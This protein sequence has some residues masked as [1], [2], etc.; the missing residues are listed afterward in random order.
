MREEPFSNSPRNQECVSPWSRFRRLFL[1]LV[2]DDDG[3]EATCHRASSS[4]GAKTATE[5]LPSTTPPWPPIHPSQRGSR[6]VFSGLCLHRDLPLSLHDACAVAEPA[7]AH[8]TV[9]PRDS[10]GGD[11]AGTGLR[12]RLGS[13]PLPRTWW[14]WWTTSRLRLQALY[15]CPCQAHHLILRVPTPLIS[16]AQK[17]Q[18]AAAWDQRCRDGNEAD[19]LAAPDGT[20]A[21]TLLARDAT[22]DV[23]L[24]RV[25]IKRP[26]EPEHST[27]TS[28]SP[29]LWCIIAIVFRAVA[30]P[31]VRLGP[32]APE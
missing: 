26:C 12:V 22:V 32:I 4:T 14:W 13:S 8:V 16:C 24:N 7:V 2:A 18:N 25:G 17:V 10:F 29:A 23:P 28:A 31:P 9:C 30:S 27:S 15:G 11:C 19:L 21:A 20:L 5:S 1:R 6:G 3:V